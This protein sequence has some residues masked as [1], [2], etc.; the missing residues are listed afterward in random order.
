M[1]QELAA[2]ALA[3]FSGPYIGMPDEGHL[4]H[5]LDA[6]NA[7]EPAAFLPSPEH[8]ACVKLLPEVLHRHVGF[9][10]PVSGNVALISLRRVVDDGME[11]NGIILNAPP[12]HAFFFLPH[13]QA[14]TQTPQ[15]R[16]P[17]PG[18]AAFSFTCAWH[19]AR[20]TACSRVSK[21]ESALTHR[22]ALTGQAAVHSRQV[23]H[24]F[25]IG[26]SATSGMSVS[27]VTSLARGP[28]C[29]VTS[30]RL[31]PCQPSPAMRATALCEMAP[32]SRSS[33]MMA[34]AGTACA[35]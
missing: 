1:H 31:L 26:P 33:S 16:A 13:G 15:M 28:N 19:F 4:L 22:M 11:D 12:D 35:R 34:E 2:D 32:S 29:G 6:H 8:H 9:V 25:A 21:C 3:A 23:P 24:L 27:T 5:I 10:P 18:C 14:R 17:M 7:N 20:S 30:S